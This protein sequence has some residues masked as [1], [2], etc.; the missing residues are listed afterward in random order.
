MNLVE[1]LAYEL[2]DKHFTEFEKVRYIY[3]RCCEIFSFD[4]KWHYTN[5]FND[6]KLKEEIRNKEF[7]IYNI[8]SPLVVCHTVSKKILKPTIEELTNLEID[9]LEGEHTMCELN[10][11]AHKWGLD[12]TIGDLARVKAKLRTNGFDADF[13]D[14]DKELE[15]VDKAVGYKRNTKEYYMDL[16]RGDTNTERIQSIGRMLSRNKCRYHYS[17][18]SFY[19]TFLAA[20]SSQSAVTY[21]G[22]NYE[23]TK[24]IE[25]ANEDN[26]FKL[27]RKRDIYSINQIDKEEYE[28]L[29]RT[30]KRG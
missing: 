20:L 14:Y 2:K 12:P 6:T 18:A 22:D 10:Y 8:D 26:Y 15:E 29:K 25:V 1:Q 30:L 17:D 16:V 11:G 19:Y 7:D 28:E 3:L 27:N 13:R 9:I 23:F 24:L 21:V 4:S 5:L